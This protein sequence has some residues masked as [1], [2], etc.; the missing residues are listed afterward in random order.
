MVEQHEADDPA[1][2]QRQRIELEARLYRAV[3]EFVLAF[4]DA[5]AWT[6]A[7]IALL[8]DEPRLRRRASSEWEFERRRAFVVTLAEK[9]SVPESLRQDWLYAWLRAQELARKRDAIA[10]GRLETSGDVG[11]PPERQIG[12]TSFRKM[13][14]DPAATSKLINEI[15]LRI[16]QTR[17]LVRDIGELSSR[18]AAC[19]P[20]THRRRVCTLVQ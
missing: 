10:L 2:R 6:H 16:D 4:G 14:R 7:C 12:V 13:F 15:E 19:P 20:D 18:I 11:K 5:E 1:A 8:C 3:G 17:V 9:R